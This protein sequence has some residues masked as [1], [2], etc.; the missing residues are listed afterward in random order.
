MPRS[1][2]PPEQNLRS[3]HGVK[4]LAHTNSGIEIKRT[5][6]IYNQD[7]SI[8]TEEIGIQ[9]GEAPSIQFCYDSSRFNSGQV[10]LAFK[11]MMHAVIGDFPFRA[12]KMTKV[13]VPD[14]IIHHALQ[15]E[16]DP[17]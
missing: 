14:K 11:E 6:L 12:V 1:K 8:S 4:K 16:M 13:K 5:R 2:R 17:Q 10:H 9:K 3:T 7:G 15:H